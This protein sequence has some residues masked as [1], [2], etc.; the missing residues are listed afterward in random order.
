MRLSDL[1]IALVG[2][3]LSHL[4]SHELAVAVRAAKLLSSAAAERYTDNP[5]SAS[6]RRRMSE[7]SVSAQKPATVAAGVTHQLYIIAGRLHCSGHDPR[8]KYSRSTT[9]VLGADQSDEEEGEAGED[10]HQPFKIDVLRSRVLDSIQIT[11]VAAGATHSLALSSARTVYSFGTNEFGQLGTGSMDVRS[12]GPRLVVGLTGAACR[13]VSCGA[14]FS[15]VLSEQGW[16]YT[17]G[18][19]AYHELGLEPHDPSS[20]LAIVAWH[21]AVVPASSSVH[22][23]IGN[24]V[25]SC[26]T[27]CVYAPTLVIQGVALQQAA[28]GRSHALLLNLAGTALYA[29]GRNSHG[30]TGDHVGL[31]RRAS[32]WLWR[33][34]PLDGVEIAPGKITF[35]ACG[36]N[37]S[38]C[39][40]GGVVYTWG[41]NLG[42]QCSGVGRA[43]YSQPLGMLG[44][45][46]VGGVSEY[47]LDDGTD[48]ICCTRAAGHTFVQVAAGSHHTLA[49]SAD[50]IALRIGTGCR[51]PARWRATPQAA[52]QAGEQAAERA[53]D[54]PHSITQITAGSRSSIVVHQEHPSSMLVSMSMVTEGGA[55]LIDGN[56]FNGMAGSTLQRRVTLRG[57]VKSGASTCL[58]A[59]VAE[60]S[61]ASDLLHAQEEQELHDIAYPPGMP[62]G[63]PADL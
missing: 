6:A 32:P 25:T 60:V 36:M 9:T 52:E 3:L 55:D 49:L 44:S 35:I 1:P 45:G 47:W 28:G 40:K 50:G 51:L 62:H 31:L 29:T 15:M 26:V 7:L 27:S 30:Q 48:S 54:E 11:E 4:S 57:E 5:G 13:R 46:R 58:Q 22:P 16:L 19:N 59:T 10:E 24:A 39:V 38:A 56:L 53:A 17:W 43:T 12:H 34:V 63:W 33:R 21:A 41:C 61:A 14:Y 42:R 20:S 23:P 8:A 2:E 18:S 37:H